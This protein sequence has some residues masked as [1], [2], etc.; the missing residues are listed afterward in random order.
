MTRTSDTALLERIEI[1]LDAVPRSATNPEPVGKF[2]LFRPTGPWSY[3]ARPRL[4]LGL[5]AGVTAADVDS[6][7]QRQRELKLPENI[8]WIVQT[9]PSL[10][11]AVRESGLSVIEYPLLV[12][13]GD[14][15]ERASVPDGVTVRRVAADDP[16]FVHAHAVANVGFGAAGTEIGAE[17]AVA[18]D[19][20]AAEMRPAVIDFMRDRAR[21]GVSVTYA[22]F[23]ETGPIAV[24]THQPVDDATEIVGVAT[25]PVA[26]RRGLAAAVTTALVDDSMS[27]GVSTILLSAGSDAVA[28]VYE[29]VG[30]RRIGFAG[31]AEA[32]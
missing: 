31:S 20:K 1:Y 32:A 14:G 23:D 26:R 19:E 3:Y 11:A 4:G 25:L 2:T 24:A 15:A 28:R 7:R 6:L 21:S 27:S 16:D 22:A 5:D 13:A 18:R 17:G 12:Y 9:T 8:E 29:R 30:F 10:G